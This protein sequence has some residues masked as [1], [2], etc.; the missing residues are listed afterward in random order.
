MTNA[1]FYKTPG[2]LQVA[3][4]NFCKGNYDEV[5]ACK[6]CPLSGQTP[7]CEIFFALA[8]HAEPK[9]TRLL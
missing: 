5:T 1:E 4:D 7:A 2:S 6:E 3:Y 8:E 9:Q